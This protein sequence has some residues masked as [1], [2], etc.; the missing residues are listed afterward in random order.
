MRSAGSLDGVALQLHGACAAEGVDDVEGYLLS[1]TRRVVGADIPIV[2]SLDHH[3]NV[4]TKMVELSTAIVGHRTQPHDQYDTGSIGADL[5]FRITDEEIAPVTAWRKIPL[6]SHQEQYLT[7]KGPMKVW[8]DRARAMESDPAVLQISNFPMQTWLDVEEGG[9]SVVVVTNGDLDLAESLAD[10]LAELAWS[11]RSEFQEK[12]SLAPA[13]AVTKAASTDGLVVLSDTGDSV[14]GGAG[15]DSTVLLREMVDSGVRGALVPIVDPVAAAELVSYAEGDQ[16]TFAV[17]GRLARVHEPITISGT[18]RARGPRTVEVGGGY[19]SPVVDL[20]LT[21][22]VD[23][24]VGTIVVTSLPGVGGV[25]PDMY[26]ELGIDPEEYEMAV[27]K[28]ASN[29]QYFVAR[30]SSE[31]VRADTPGPT[32]SDIADLPWERIPR[33]VYPLDQIDQWR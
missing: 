13:Q 9:W 31:V 27:L 18:L 12:S 24:D 15:G 1:V 28:T 7:S 30:F 5:L 20:G 8:F 26:Y 29:F 32:Q 33:P 25:H 4:T 6:I 22:I 21:A 23:A 19:S 17:G 14:L 2:M 16:G 10:E 11:M 3:A